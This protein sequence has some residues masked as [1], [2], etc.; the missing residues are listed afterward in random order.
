E[1]EW[2]AG[3]DP[4]YDGIRDPGSTP[5][6]VEEADN[7]SFLDRAFDWLD[8]LMDV[9]GDFIGDV[10]E[11]T[12][13]ALGNIGR[14]LQQIGLDILEAAANVLSGIADWWNGLSAEIQD[15]ILTIIAV[16]AA[17]AVAIGVAAIVAAL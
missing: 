15:L 8:G 9:A 7:P 1:T 11:A 4:R 12:V 16:V 3:E 10:Y 2:R 13:D 5:P 17:V 14:E 6:R